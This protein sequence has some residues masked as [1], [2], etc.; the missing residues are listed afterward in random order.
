VIPGKSARYG[1][2]EAGA[3]GAVAGGWLVRSRSMSR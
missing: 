3:P 1:L 2:G